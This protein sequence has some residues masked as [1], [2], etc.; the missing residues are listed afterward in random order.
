MSLLEFREKLARELIKEDHSTEEVPQVKRYRHTLK[1]MNSRKRCQPCYK[2]IRKDGFSAKEAAIKC[3]TVNT[4]CADCEIA[5]CLECFN[6][7][8]KNM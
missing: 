3:K 7:T 6:K 2:A 1:K 4:H 5:I 8:H